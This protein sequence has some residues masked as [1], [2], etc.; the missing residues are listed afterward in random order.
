MNRTLALFDF[1]G[2]ITVKDSTL[3]FYKFLYNSKVLFLYNH[4]FLCLHYLFLYKLKLISYM[5]LKSKR[6][7]IH[8]SKFNDSEISKLSE[9]YYEKC[10]F[11]ILNSKAIDRI[12]WH[13]NQGHEVWVISASYD[14]LLKKWSEQNGLN[15]ITNKTFF[16]HCKRQI[17]GKDVNY[18]SKVEYLKLEVD[19]NDYSEIYAYGDS[20]GDQAMLDFANFK[21]F[22]P[23]RN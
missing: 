10:F 23:F 11:R 20:E 19:Q 13:K 2:T 12:N 6:L 8:T 3:S 14:F 15:L 1:D 9:Q 22:K 7:D 18:D 16:K 5:T 21:F 17:Y 4:Y